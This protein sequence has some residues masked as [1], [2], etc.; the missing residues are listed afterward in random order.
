MEIRQVTPPSVLPVSL[1]EARWQCSLLDGRQDDLLLTLIRSA[2]AYVET[3]IRARLCEQT[4]MFISP[5]FPSVLPIYPVQ[6]I[7]SV[8]YIDSDGATQAL[9]SADYYI[10]T[11]SM[12][13]KMTAITDWPAVDDRPDAVKITAVMGFTATPEDIKAAILMRVKESFDRRSESVAGIST[14]PAFVRIADLLV[15]HRMLP[16]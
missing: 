7:T 9:D 2:S 8:E 6:S 15:P 13:P 4:V 12:Y 1:S 10:T 11:A 5:K 14:A 16:L 3:H